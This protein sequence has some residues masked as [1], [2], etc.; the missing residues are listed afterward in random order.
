MTTADDD[1]WKTLAPPRSA[2]AINARRVDSAIPW[3]FFWAR[4]V[5][6]RFLLVLRHA[7][8]SSPDARLPRLRGLEM[9]LSDGDEDG[10][11]V[12]VLRLID[13][14]HRDIFL[15][16]CLDIVAAA[17]RASSEREAVG[18]CLG[19]TWR[20]HHLLRGGGDGRLS[21]EEQKGLIGELIVLE[22]LILPNRSVSDAV[23]TWRGPL[24][25]PKDF[26]IGRVCIEAKARR[27]A[28]TPHLAISS[29]HQL[30]ASGIDV[31]FLHVAELDHEQ[32]TM[33]DA[34][35][36]T[37]IA[38]RCEAAILHHDTW[39]AESFEHL[40]AATGFRWEDDYTNMRWT[41]GRH[42]LFHVGDTFPA[43]RSGPLPAGVADVRYTVSLAECEGHRVT[44]E[45]VMAALVEAR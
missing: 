2:D 21:P 41:E 6:G 5:D 4:G 42:H 1:P 10:V 26:E 14:A 23:S 19:R 25:A 24:G 27:G 34:F 17:A 40:L 18:L 8:E 39:A 33:K 7:A 29:E 11:R 43:I 13:P 30:D 31:L 36:L 45:T 37:E 22:T 44:T 32:S 9:T 20:W 3:G 28:A 38:R 15:R 12:L 16:L 35:T